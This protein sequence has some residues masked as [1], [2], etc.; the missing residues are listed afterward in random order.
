MNLPSSVLS[1]GGALYDAIIMN[2]KVSVNCHCG[3]R[4]F[5]QTR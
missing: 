5:S 2:A 1:K 3:E 4:Q